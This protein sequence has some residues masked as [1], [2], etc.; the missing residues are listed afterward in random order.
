MTTDDM[1]G[2]EPREA[3]E[4]V[5]AEPIPRGLLRADEICVHL[6][7]SQDLLELC[8]RWEVIEP[9]EAEEGVLLFGQSAVERIRRALRL[10]HDLGINWPGVA[11][12]LDLLER[13]E[14]LER[15]RQA[16]I[17]WE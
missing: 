15:Q 17:E 11:I 7:I 16:G 5:E 13:V 6:G 2:P 12:V 8:L 1:R 4:P 9:P 3:M 14:K 10:H